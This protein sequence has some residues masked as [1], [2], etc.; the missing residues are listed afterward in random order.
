MPASSPPPANAAAGNIA[1][2][3]SV[4]NTNPFSS[5]ST[6][7]AHSSASSEALMKLNLKPKIKLKS[8]SSSTVNHNSYTVNS[9]KSSRKVRVKKARG[10]SSSSRPSS[11]R[12]MMTTDFYGD[13]EDEMG[14]NEFLDMLDMEGGGGGQPGDFGP[15]ERYNNSS[16]NSQELGKGTSLNVLTTFQ[17]PLPGRKHLIVDFSNGQSVTSS[18]LQ[19][20]LN[21]G[22]GC[23]VDGR[24][25]VGYS[26][27]PPPPPSMN[28][29]LHNHN[30]NHNPF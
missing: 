12:G 14:G 29:H 28:P 6:S 30:G 18:I 4:S 17:T 24:G 22:G 21:N 9:D 7:S 15:D 1:V 23:G 26:N 19:S 2:A 3:T 10:S 8:T 27:H 11:A 20:R 13:D 25:F 16:G 5:H